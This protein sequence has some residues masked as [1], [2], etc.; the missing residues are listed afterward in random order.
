MATSAGDQLRGLAGIA[1]RYVSDTVR[2]TVEP[3]I[4]LRWVC[5]SDLPA[6]HRELDAIGL[7]RPGAQSIG[8]I[9]ACPGTDT[10]KLGIASS[11][12]LAAELER[13]VRRQMD[14]LDDA[15][16]PQNA[17]ERSIIGYKPL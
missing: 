17:P 1:R 5:E 2:T 13:Q 4:V 15:V 14:T 7:D 8:N 16:P 11:R 3:N 9:T 12:G 10:S 6:L